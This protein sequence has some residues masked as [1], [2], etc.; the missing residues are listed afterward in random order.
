ASTRSADAIASGSV[1]SGFCTE[2]TLAVLKLARRCPKNRRHD[3]LE[4]APD[5]RRRAFFQRDGAGHARADQDALW[6]VR[7][8]DGDG[9]TLCQS[10]PSECW[11]DRREELWTIFIILVRDAHCYA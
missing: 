5:L 11:I 6:H 9:D 7:D 2:V 1:V 8:V 3:F 4:A 10:D